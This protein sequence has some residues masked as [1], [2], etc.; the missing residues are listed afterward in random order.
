LLVVR[1]AVVGPFAENTLLVADT[2]SKEA[3]LVDPGGDLPRALAL[4]E[5]EGFRVTRI[6]LTHGHIDHVAG[7]AEAR[8]RLG[9]PCQIHGEDCEWLERLPEQARVFGFAGAGEAPQ[10]DH[11][12]GEGETVSLGKHAG[13]IL[14][15]PG[16]S[17]GSCC[18]HFDEA[19]TLIVGDTLFAGSV[20]RTDL[21]GGDFDQLAASIR[22]KLFPLG[23]DVRFFP[24]HGPAGKLGDER[25]SNPFVGDAARRDRFI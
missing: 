17:A 6:F 20:G 3:L 2:E 19:R 9:V 16:H 8:A 4:L 14:H 5:P 12:H 1:S 7:C 23:N 18:L 11:L 10:I 25:R 24:G 22:E 21:P 13:R 15:T